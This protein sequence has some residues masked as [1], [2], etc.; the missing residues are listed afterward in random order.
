[1]F[2]W[3]GTWISVGTTSWEEN[4]AKWEQYGS[5]WA[6]SYAGS[7]DSKDAGQYYGGCAVDNQA[8]FDEHGKVL[9][10][11]KVFSLMKKGNE[12]AL[13][14]DGTEER[15]L[16]HAF[17]DTIELPTKIN[18]VMTDDSKQE[19]NVT[20]NKLSVVNEDTSVTKIMDIASASDYATVIEYLKSHGVNKYQL[21]G[22][23]DNLTSYCY[24]SMVDYNYLTNYSFEDD[25]NLTKVPTGWTT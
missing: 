3:E 13:K 15:T 16:I 7:Y 22:K 1:M 25:A 4:S 23:A 14:V 20:W 2:Y 5:G 9:E 19:V 17:T 18:A 24:V 12:I 10:S 8:F 21:E 11:L 6:S